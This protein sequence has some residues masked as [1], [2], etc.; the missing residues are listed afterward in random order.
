MA[1]HGGGDDERAVALLLEDS[2][3]SL[4]T[5]GSAVQVGVDDMVPV[6]GGAVDDT[7]VGSRTGTGWGMMLANSL[8]LYSR[9]RRNVLGDEGINLAKVLEHILDQLLALLVLAHVALVGLGLD[10]VGLGEL[11]DVLLS[12]LLARSVGDGNVGAHLGTA[13]CGLNAHALGA[14]STGNDDDLALQA[15]EVLQGVGGGGLL[16]HFDF[17]W[18]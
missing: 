6:L 1:R 5:V 3:D 18:L 2:A 9:V 10:T 16:R 13:A 7:S 11:L 8:E 15:E 12:T 14:G 4:G 17:G